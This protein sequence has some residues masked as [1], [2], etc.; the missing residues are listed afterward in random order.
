MP[1]RTTNSVTIELDTLKRLIV[2]ARLARSASPEAA[3]QSAEDDI[4]TWRTSTGRP[5]WVELTAATAQQISAAAVQGLADL[6]GCDQAWR[7]Q[8][9]SDLKRVQN[10]CRSGP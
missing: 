9:G 5:Q 7:T 8:V 10:G 4:A 6:P 3:E 2:A 1:P